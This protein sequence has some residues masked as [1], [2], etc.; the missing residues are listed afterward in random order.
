MKSLPVR[1]PP[2]NSEAPKSSKRIQSHAY[3]RETSGGLP[4]FLFAE[5]FH[6]KLLACEIPQG[7]GSPCQMTP[8]S[9]VRAAYPYSLSVRSCN[10]TSYP[11][12]SACTFEPQTPSRQDFWHLS[13]AQ[14][15]FLRVIY[16]EELIEEFR[17]MRRSMS[18]DLEAR[19]VTICEPPLRDCVPPSGAAKVRLGVLWKGRHG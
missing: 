18:H 8:L 11:W 5:F 17:L 19:V 2:L 16:S 7:S 15:G 6:D 1:R 10:R 9:S 12:P 13:E 14:V 4:D 3:T